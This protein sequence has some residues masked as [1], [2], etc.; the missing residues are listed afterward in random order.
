MTD[1]KHINA[2]PLNMIGMNIPSIYGGILGEKYWESKQDQ[3]LQIDRQ[4]LRKSRVDI[5]GWYGNEETVYE[6]SSNEEEEFKHQ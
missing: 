6:T 4:A 3:K 5:K 1:L 2:D